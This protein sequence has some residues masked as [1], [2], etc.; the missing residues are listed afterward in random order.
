M[1]ARNLRFRSLLRPLSRA[2]MVLALLVMLSS[3]SRLEAQSVI[4]NTLHSVEEREEAYSIDLGGGRSHEIT[5]HQ[6][7]FYVRFTED[8]NFIFGWIITEAPLLHFI[9]VKKAFRR[10]GIAKALCAAANLNSFEY[11]L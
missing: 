6:T 2:P 9:F 10:F 7:Q 11:I 3:A 4:Q 5:K 8:E 1:D